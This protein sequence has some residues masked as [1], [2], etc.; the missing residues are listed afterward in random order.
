VEF[1]I[2]ERAGGVT[3]RVVE[4]GFQNLKKDRAAIDNQIREN[5]HGWEVELEAAR[6]FVLEGGG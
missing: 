6:R 5:T 4:S 1:W 2:E 3:L